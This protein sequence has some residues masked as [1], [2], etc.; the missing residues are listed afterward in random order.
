MGDSV[1][2]LNEQLV[3]APASEWKLVNSGKTLTRPLRGVELIVKASEHY[4]DGNVSCSLAKNI[5]N[6]HS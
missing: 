4:N 6:I 5:Y 2:Q 1:Q 3:S